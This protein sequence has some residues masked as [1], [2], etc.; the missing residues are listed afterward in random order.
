MKVRP[1]R[2]WL[3]VTTIADFIFVGG[4]LFACFLGLI[5]TEVSRKAFAPILREVYNI[6]L[7]SMNKPGYLGIV[8][9][10]VNEEGF[11]EWIP[12]TVLVILWV[13][14]LFFTTAAIILWCMLQIFWEFNKS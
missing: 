4:I 14:F 7:F 6:D 8:Y 5:P 3:I 11:K 2:N 13:I 1:W 9:W 10:V 12:R